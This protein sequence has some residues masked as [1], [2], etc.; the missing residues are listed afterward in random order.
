M[1]KI[2]ELVKKIVELNPN[3]ILSGSVALNLQ[4]VK[5]RTAPNDIDFLLPFGSAKLKLPKDSNEVKDYNPDDYDSDEYRRERYKC[6]NVE[7]D[8]F[9]QQ[10]ETMHMEVIKRQGIRQLNKV[11]IIS[12]KIKH[13]LDFS[14]SRNKQKF[15][16]I[17]ILVNN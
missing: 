16:I 3:I 7:F 9:I 11:D 14:V 8:V 17:H 13:A 10:S 1:E 15:D 12:F 2:L 5:T 6:D 4:Q